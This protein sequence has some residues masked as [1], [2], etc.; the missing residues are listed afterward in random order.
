M[1]SGCGTVD[2]AVASGTEGPGFKSNH[3]QF[4][5]IIYLLSTISRIDQNEEER[6]RTAHFKTSVLL[7]RRCKK[8][9]RCLAILYARYLTPQPETLIPLQYLRRNSEYFWH[10]MFQCEHFHTKMLAQKSIADC[11]LGNNSTTIGRR[12]EGG[13]PGLVVLAGDSC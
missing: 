1:G 2:S 6:P 13:R 3:C 4:L 12:L 10:Q 5:L 7:V 9:L 11:L 8:H